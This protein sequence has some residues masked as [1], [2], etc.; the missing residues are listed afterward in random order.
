MNITEIQ[1][2]LKENKITCSELVEQYL[3]KI[4]AGK[5]YNAFITVFDE[6][7]RKK[8]EELDKKLKEN[9]AGTLA[10]VITGIKDVICIKGERNTC[11][12]K[13]LENYYP[14]Y[15]ATVIEQLEKEDAIII[16]KLNM[17]EFAMG[18]TTESSYFGPTLNP[19]DITRIPGGSS[20]GAAAAIAADL[21]TVTLGSDTGGSIRQPA[22]MCGVVGIKPTYG[23]VSRFGLVAYA[24]SLDQIGP[25]TSNVKD[26]AIILKHIAG[27]DPKDSTS[28]DI[29]VPDYPNLLEKDAS[30][31]K[32][33]I[34]QEYCG[35]GLD[36]EIKN[37]L[38]ILAKKLQNQGIIVEDVSLPH[39]EYSIATY[40]II[41]TAEASSNLSRYD[42]VKYGYREKN[43]INLDDL[44]TKS[45]THGF[46]KEVKRRIML[47][48]YVLSSGYYDAYYNKARKFRKLIKDDFDKAFEKFDCLITPVSPTVAYKLGDKIDDPLQMYLSDIYTI[49]INLAGI[50][51]LTIPFGKSSEGLPIGFQI[52]GKH[53]SEEVI[54]RLGHFIEKLNTPS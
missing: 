32:V 5:K 36:S 39:S 50:P 28:V 8:A 53:F 2:L 43:V 14:P 19:H 34:P 42:G 49:S 15:N 44:F 29:E 23:R 6:K 31:L 27:K 46:G 4:E 40:Y 18:S 16:G 37:K 17:D 24:S 12:S 10:G 51:G 38:E 52:L 3:S 22:A 33:G 7:A 20:G 54:L 25:I 48:T 45:R 13:M 1:K 11:G 9:N 47:G 21:C 41:A 35:E 30:G 26:S